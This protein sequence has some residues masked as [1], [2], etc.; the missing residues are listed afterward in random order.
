MRAQSEGHPDAGAFAVALEYSA[1][2]GCADVND[3]KAIVVGRLGYDAFR[4]DARDRVIVDIASRGNS[5]E[6]TSSGA[7]LKD[8]GRAIGRSRPAATT[9]ASSGAPWPLRWH[10][11]FSFPRGPVLSGSKQDRRRLKLTTRRR[12]RLPRFQLRWPARRP[13]CPGR[14]PCPDERSRRHSTRAP[15]DTQHRGRRV[16][17]L[18]TVL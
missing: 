6:G 15:A 16:A 18:R 10:C 12:P 5:F 13:Q 1:A 2:P 14:H 7:T 4:E 17:G 3:F 9:A 8:G 11:R